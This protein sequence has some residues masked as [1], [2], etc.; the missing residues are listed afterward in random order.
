MM[1]PAM[2]HIRIL[3]LLMEETAEARESRVRCSTTGVVRAWSP[4]GTVA[5]HAR[6]DH[7]GDQ[8]RPPSPT[9]WAPASGM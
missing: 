8:G 1:M 2:I 7:G 3:V 6:R 9:A 4:A 5:G